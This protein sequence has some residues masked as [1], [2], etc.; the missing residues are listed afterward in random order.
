MNNKL[1]HL[2]LCVCLCT[3]VHSVKAQSNEEIKTAYV[4]KNLKLN[5]KTA[6]EFKPICLAYFNAMKVAKSENSALKTKYKQVIKSGQLT[7]SQAESLLKAN[8]VSDKREIA[9][10]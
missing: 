9:V 6:D 10:N 4:I 8:W 7:N 2:L 3:L 1:Y 5:K